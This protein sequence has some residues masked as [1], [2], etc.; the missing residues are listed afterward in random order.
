MMFYSRFVTEEFIDELEEAKEKEPER[1]R[2]LEEA[3]YTLLFLFD[4]L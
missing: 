1:I 3:H 4:L 2:R